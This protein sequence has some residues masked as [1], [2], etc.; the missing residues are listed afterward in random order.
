[1]LLATLILFMLFS[2]TFGYSTNGSKS[3]VPV[4]TE[5][6]KGSRRNFL[7]LS[8]SL[9]PLCAPAAASA[10]ENRLDDKYV[11]VKPSIGPQPDDS[12]KHLLLLEHIRG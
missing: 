12:Q 3:S 10:F 6:G 9:I 1:M 7:G 11:D 2:G 5:T 4:L 8:F